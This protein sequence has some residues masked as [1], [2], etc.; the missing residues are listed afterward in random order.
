[1][2]KK[3][4]SLKIGIVALVIVSLGLITFLSK[5]MDKS[6]STSSDN[7]STDVLMV[8]HNSGI[9]QIKKEPKRV[10]VFDY[11]ILD[12]LS[13][14]NVEVVGVPKSGLPEYLSEQYSSSKYENI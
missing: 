10:V 14:L 2:S 6:A 8:E 5:N 4:L 1:M 13:V 3:S 11:G 12:A 9:T 7:I